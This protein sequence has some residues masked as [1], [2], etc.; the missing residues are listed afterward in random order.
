MNFN[1]P[2]KLPDHHITNPF[3]TMQLLQF[4]NTRIPWRQGSSVSQIPSPRF[5][6]LESLILITIPLKSL[7][8][9]LTSR[10]C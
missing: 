4:L 10:A 2:I 1:E 5:S 8:K 9:F 7:K 3:G 6:V